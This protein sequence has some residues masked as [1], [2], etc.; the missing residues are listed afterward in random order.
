MINSLTSNVTG[1]DAGLKSIVNAFSMW[2]LNKK[3]GKTGPL[4]L[5]IV[6]PNGV[7][8]SETGDILIEC[9]RV[10]LVTLNMNSAYVRRMINYQY[11]SLQMK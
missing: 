5:A 10:C 7:G 8:K 1:Q 4:V 3:S 9:I 6:G 2:E 11:V